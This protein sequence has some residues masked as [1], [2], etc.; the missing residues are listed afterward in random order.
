M[1]LTCYGLDVRGVSYKVIERTGRVCMSVRCI[2]YLRRDA[3]RRAPATQF[4]S[5]SSALSPKETW[6]INIGIWLAPQLIYIVFH[7]IH[8]SQKVGLLDCRKDGGHSSCRYGS[9]PQ[10]IILELFL[11]DGCS[12]PST[13]F[14]IHS[15]PYIILILKNSYDHP[16]IET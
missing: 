3:V 8:H 16:S 9:V 10:Y 2:P 1:G 6:C 5:T 11:P 7:R 12:L 4:Q 13:T 14:Y 15:S